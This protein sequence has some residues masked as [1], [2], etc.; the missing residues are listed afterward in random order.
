[1]DDR[2]AIEKVGQVLKDCLKAPARSV[3]DDVE[4]RILSIVMAT[5]VTAERSTREYEK[6]CDEF[7]ESVIVAK[8]LPVRSIVGHDSMPAGVGLPKGVALPTDKMRAQKRYC[9]ETYSRQAEL[10]LKGEMVA[11][12]TQL[13]EF[14]TE[15]FSENPASRELKLKVTAIKRAFRD[16]TK[17]DRFFSTVKNNSFP[18]AINRTFSFEGNPLAVKWSYSSLDETGEF[19]NVYSH[20]ELADRLYAIRGNWALEKGLMKPGPHG[21][22]EDAPV[23]GE[24]FDC[25]CRYQF[26]YN[27]RGLPESMLTPKG[28]SELA[29]AQAEVSK[30]LGK[31][32]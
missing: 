23:P 7:F 12:R 2:E 13:A 9:V 28:S 14:L 20:K 11:F 16:L 25:M 6:R 10:Y 19:R 31:S 15:A 30:L 3:R 1:M 26:I 5:I 17:W 29:R 24:E 21:Y 27:L 18:S 4:N 22:V 8:G 32:S